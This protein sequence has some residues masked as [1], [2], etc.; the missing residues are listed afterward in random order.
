M[1]HLAG[2]KILLG[3]CGSIA[4]YKS[5]FLARWFMKQGAE[6]RVIM[7]PSAEDFVTPLTFSALTKYPVY[8]EVSGET[9]W[10]NHVELGLWADAMIIA[11][12]TANT[13]SKMANGMS[14]NMVVATYL[15]A[16]C[17][18]WIAPAMD[19]DM[20][21]HPSTKRNIH[22]LLEDKVQLIPPVYGE[23]ASGLVGIGRLA[24]PEEIGKIINEYFSKDKKWKGKKILITAG[25]THEPIDPVR[26]IG[27]E[28]TGKMGIAIA[29]EFV[30][31][32]AMVELI[33][34]PT[35]IV[36][37][38]PG[39]I[40]HKIQ[41]AKEMYDEV[42]EHFNDSNVVV[43][44]AAVADFRPVE[45]SNTK[46]KKGDSSIDIQLEPTVDIAASLGSIK[47]ASI[48]LVG[49]ALET[50]NEENNAINKLKSKNLDMIVLNSLKDQ[51]A[52][53]KVD[54]NKV[55]I[56]FKD[57][58]QKK[59]ELKSKKEVASDIVDCIEEL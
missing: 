42:L 23:L 6:L 37:E 32:G 58:K 54:T 7:T 19:L 26:Y 36:V 34:G 43:L 9:G 31:R 50:D 28:S 38:N 47:K 21:K 30:K 48:K 29:E 5:A 25:P 15:S 16:R 13:L 52:G 41:T 17:P 27:N 51:G 10:N 46:I 35:Y 18:V 40:V 55:T 59:F 57:N 12:L 2:K 8:S 20:W 44:C 4:A 56:Y 1:N 33:L 45:K 49:F 14:D 53:F 11:P 39:I 3:V 22:K 24:E